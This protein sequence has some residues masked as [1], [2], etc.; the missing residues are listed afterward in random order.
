RSFPTS[1]TPR[2]QLHMLSCLELVGGTIV[3]SAPWS[4]PPELSAAG[5]DNHH[6]IVRRTCHGP[7]SPLGRG[8][9][10]ACES[11]ACARG[12][13]NVIPIAWHSSMAVDSSM[14]ACAS[15]PLLV[16]RVPRARWQ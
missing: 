4:Q 12:S 8:L 2:R 15:W 16:D 1:L 3:S 6:Y 11:V 9:P 5:E 7:Y 10:P 13:Q 14:R